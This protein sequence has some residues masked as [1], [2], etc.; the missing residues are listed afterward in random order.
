MRRILLAALVCT[1]ALSG[2]A[3]AQGDKTKYPVLTLEGKEAPAFSTDFAINANKATLTDLKGKVVLID[4]WAVWCGPCVAVFPELS[5]L[6]RD[7]GP[8]GLEV[9]GVTRYYKNR[10]FKDGKLVAAKEPLK[11][12]QEQEMLKAFA[13]HHK[14]PYRI[15]TSEDAFKA[16]KITAIP[17]AV[18]IDKK[19]TVQMVKVGSSKAGIKALEE[20]IK[21]LLD[22][23]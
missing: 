5:R 14:L 7:Y 12:E 17:S 23:K 22:E 15:Q 18:L 13:R 9:V 20:K 11:P 21:A 4:F 3:P 2:S 1:A 19:G 6:H 8:K 10:D 16:Y